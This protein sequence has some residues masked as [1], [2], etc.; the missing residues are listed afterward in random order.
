MILLPLGNDFIA[1]LKDSSLASV[2]S[3]QELTYS[4]NLLNARTFRA[5]ETYNM[6]ALLYLVMTLLGSMGVRA[7]ERVLGEPVMQAM[8][9]AEVRPRANAVDGV[10]VSANPKALNRV[11]AEVGMVFQQFNL[12][13]FMDQGQIVEEGPPAVF[14]TQPREERTRAFLSKIL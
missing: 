9:G 6:V 7:M 2:L 13:V 12:I 10:E 5:F 3:V 1:L 14:F 11:R 8:A 4:G